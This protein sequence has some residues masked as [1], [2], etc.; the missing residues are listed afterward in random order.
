M[1]C[2]KSADESSISAEHLHYAPLNFLIRLTRL[3]NLMLKHSFVPREFWSG[4]MIPILKDLHGNHS[5]TSN[6]RGITISP[7]LSKLFEH[8]LKI[9]FGDALLTS[10]YQFGFKKRSSTTHALHCLHETTNYY[11]AHGSRVFCS[12]LDASKAFDRLVHSGLFIKL[13]ERNVPLPFLNII[14]SWYDGL[15]CRVKWGECFS[16]WFCITPGV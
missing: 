13:M 1:K 7:I 15:Q 9:V 14:M 4:F 6:Y 5:D 2:G 12:F 10:N 11:I 8:I 3:F 16:Q